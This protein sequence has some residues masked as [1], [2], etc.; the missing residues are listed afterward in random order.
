MDYAQL[1]EDVAN[2]LNREDLADTIPSFIRLAESWLNKSLRVRQMLKRAVAILDEQYITLPSDWLEAKN[3][4][5]N[6]KPA[7][8]LEFVTLDQADQIRERTGGASGPPYFY[9]ISG[10]Q[11]E[12]VPSPGADVEI[13]MAYYARIPAL[14]DD[15]PTNWL[16]TEWP[17]IYL[18]ASLVHSAPFLQDDERVA[19]WGSLLREAFEAAQ[20]ADQRAQYSGAP[21]KVRTRKLGV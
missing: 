10:S 20:Q 6:L 7:R 15:A 18:Y 12:V 11:L 8:R 1:Q 2:W 17:D 16:L 21:L 13:E 19:V 3:V 9:T 4:Q 5:L 14:S